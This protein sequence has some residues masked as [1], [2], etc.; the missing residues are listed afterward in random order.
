MAKRIISFFMATVICITCFVV[1]ASAVQ[2]LEE[3]YD[4][5]MAQ[6]SELLLD[7]GDT[8]EAVKKL[9]R[10]TVYISVSDGKNRA[11]TVWAST[12]RLSSAL[13]K[14]FEKA[15]NTGVT[16]E[17]FKL[18][19]VTNIQSVDRGEFKE[20]VGK[21]TKGGLR[22]GISFI[23]TFGQSIPEGHINAEGMLD[24]ET[25]ELNL[26]KINAY[27]KRNKKKQLSEIPESFIVF[28]S[29][30]YF[31][32]GTAYKLLN[33]SRNS[34]ARRDFP[35]DKA[36][37]EQLAEM[38][39]SYLASLC[40]N[41]GKFIYG[42]Y[43][44]DN[45]KMEDYNI[46][47]HA[48][49]V[50]NL[51]LQYDMTKN[52]EIVPAIDRA[53]D[54]LD[55]YI[56]YKDKNTAFL[57]NS[58]SLNVGGNGISLLAYTAYADIFNTDKYNDVIKALAN[59]IIFMQKDS[60][61]FTHAL[62]K[63]DYTVYK[64]YIVIFYD[65]EAMYGLCRA[66]SVL[67]TK[68]FLHAAEKAADYFIGA[69]YEKENSHWISYGFNELTK[70]SPKKKYFNFGLL[71]VHGFTKKAYKSATGSPTRGETLGAAFELYDRLIQSGKSCEMLDEF[72]EDM[73]FKAFE[74]RIFYGLNYLMFPE[75][76]MYFSDPQTV[77]N[78]FAIRESLFRIRIDD[79]Q[80]FMG[81]YYLYWKNYDR[82]KYYTTVN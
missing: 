76:A 17:W 13:N 62:K 14:A 65:G 39:S 74:Q 44:I 70:Y 42:Y 67:G 73:L 33:G 45:E 6:V 5:R 78:S 2:T 29:Q 43:P 53:L 58:R 7:D 59:G 26:E 15:K 37:L 69:H 38:S 48:G 61:A 35:T 51:I 22:R 56:Q 60:G 19:V 27:F 49:T 36:G 11:V 9:G 16:P 28:D 30:S 12:K 72:D 21:Q 75:S 10:A 63:S 50:W 31:S 71:N 54:Y 8:V 4:E 55:G 52:D 20:L 77:L 40:D 24:Y 82:V 41:S 81:G 80:H 18:E 57:V 1:P 68:K 46:I 34:I 3:K 79:I 23:E 66:Y 64:D 47:R 32:D 25:A